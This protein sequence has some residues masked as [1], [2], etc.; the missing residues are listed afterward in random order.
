MLCEGS[1]EVV[2]TAIL[3]DACILAS[4]IL[5]FDLPVLLDDFMSHVISVVC[6]G[7]WSGRLSRWL[8]IGDS[9]LLGALMLQLFFCK[10]LNLLFYV[11]WIRQ[12]F[13]SSETWILEH[14]V[15]GNLL[16]CEYFVVDFSAIHADVPRTSCLLY[17]ISSLN[18]HATGS[19]IFAL[20]TLIFIIPSLTW[21]WWQSRV[22]PQF[23]VCF[24]L[25]LTDRGSPKRRWWSFILLLSPSTFI[26]IEIKVEEIRPYVFV[27]EAQSRRTRRRSP[28][29]FRL[30]SWIWFDGLRV[31]HED[32]DVCVEL[33]EF[34]VEG[35]AITKAIITLLISQGWVHS[36]KDVIK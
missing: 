11:I 24:R 28:H 14:L 17:G 13:E 1:F 4:E 22:L 2:H 36:Q 5:E 19:L 29:G 8:P 7:R 6:N 25:L 34:L 10:L 23:T 32:I 35:R 26:I 9:L 15:L 21:N 18:F 30:E 12:D 31:G 20:L 3:K 27:I 16:A 33:L